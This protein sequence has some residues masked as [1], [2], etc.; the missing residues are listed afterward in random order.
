MRDDS[1]EVV[2]YRYGYMAAGVKRDRGLVERV[3][4]NSLARRYVCGLADSVSA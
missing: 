3:L 4:D 2:F 1:I